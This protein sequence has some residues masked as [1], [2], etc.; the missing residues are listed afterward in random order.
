MAKPQIVEDKELDHLIKVTRATTEPHAL[1]NVA[2]IYTIFGTGMMPSEAAS[3][4]VENYMN[5]QGVPLNDTE[6]SADIAFNGRA[7]PLMWTN[8]KLVAAI[9]AYLAKRIEQGLGVELNSSSYRGLDPGSPLFLA[10]GGEGFSF[11][12]TKRNGKTYRACASLTNLLNKLIAGAG[13]EGCNTSSARRTL[14]VKLHRKHVDLR[15]INEILGQS[16]LTA[17]KHLVQGDT[18]RLSDLVAGVI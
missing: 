1:R 14:A 12:V 17:T 2:L 3:L 15:T 8:K 16:S 4:K 13:L 9:D 18:R 11:R 10:K 6:I 5:S 7:R